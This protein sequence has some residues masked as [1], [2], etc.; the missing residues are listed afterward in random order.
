MDN[1]LNSEFFDNCA[2]AALKRSADFLR[3]AHDSLMLPMYRQICLKLA[4]DA[5]KD[6]TRSFAL[7]RVY[8]IRG[9]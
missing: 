6:A 9:M 8:R 7:A 5:G 2:Y 1:E 4:M 3:S